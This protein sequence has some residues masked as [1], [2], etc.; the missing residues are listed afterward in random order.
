MYIW[1]T[2]IWFSSSCA[3]VLQ[4]TESLLLWLEMIVD[5]LAW[6]AIRRGKKY[7]RIWFEYEQCKKKKNSLKKLYYEVG[8]C[9]HPKGELW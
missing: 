1:C 4:L 2:C 8:V 3:I 5:L 7:A 6:I 9:G